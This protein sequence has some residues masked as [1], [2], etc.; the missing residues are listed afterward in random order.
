MEN[1]SLKTVYVR[2]LK[3]AVRKFSPIENKALLEIF[4]DDGKIKSITRAT[5]LGD[6]KVLSMQLINELALNEKNEEMEFDGESLRDVDVIIENEQKAMLKLVDFFRTLHSRAQQVRNSKNSEGY[7]DM[8]RN[9][10]R[11]EL[12]IYGQS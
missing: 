2:L 12:M 11:M 4:F 6:A 3:V 9:I 10:Q 7:L 8:I 5:R 1:Q